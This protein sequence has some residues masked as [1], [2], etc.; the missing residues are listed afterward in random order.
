M[1]MTKQEAKVWLRERLPQRQSKPVQPERRTAQWMCP[2][3]GWVS[4]GDVDADYVECG[5]CEGA[6]KWDEVLDA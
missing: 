1:A 2:D 4:T 5:F 6:F 3:C